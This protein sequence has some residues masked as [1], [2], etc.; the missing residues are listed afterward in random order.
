MAIAAAAGAEMAARNQPAGADAE[1]E[2]EGM[3]DKA[4]ANG[5]AGQEA[6]RSWLSARK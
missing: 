1:F 5:K 6:A 4:V 2:I 3:A